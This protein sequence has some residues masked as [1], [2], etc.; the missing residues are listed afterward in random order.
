ML[1]ISSTVCQGSKPIH[2]GKIHNEDFTL[3][4]TLHKNMQME[5]NDV[6]FKMAD[7]ALFRPKNAKI[8]RMIH[9]IMTTYTIFFILKSRYIRW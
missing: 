3:K 7:L 4:K 1:I 5:G 9:P 2:I 6:I 8:S